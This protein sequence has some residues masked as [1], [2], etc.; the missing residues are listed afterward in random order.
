[1][2]EGA[3]ASHSNGDI[4]IGVACGCGVSLLTRH[5]GHGL[6]KARAW[7]GDRSAA[8]DGDGVEDSYP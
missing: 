5:Q 7:P 1:M 4:M 8:V 6:N 2:C 3:V